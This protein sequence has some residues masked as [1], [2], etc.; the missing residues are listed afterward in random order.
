MQTHLLGGAI[1]PTIDGILKGDVKDVKSGLGER[2]F[3]RKYL[4]L[5]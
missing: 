5:W 2:N 1:K 3:L 4:E